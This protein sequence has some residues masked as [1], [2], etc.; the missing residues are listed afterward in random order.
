MNDSALASAGAA[1]AERT[2]AAMEATYW[3]A[4]RGFYAFATALPRMSPAVAEP[5][6]NV[7]ARQARLDA[8]R[9]SRLIDED[10]VLPAVPLWFGT[11]QDDRAQAELD[12][13][14]GA[15]IATDW[16]ARLLSNQSA[17][18]DPLSTTTDRCG[19]SS[20]GGRR[21]RLTGMGGRTSDSRR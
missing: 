7:R 9:A 12:H 11:V 1:S 5:G 8:M 16:G 17:L 10:T 6:P 14:G 2:R 15:A 21:W 18:Y 3:R 20:R 13:L 4:D 19:R